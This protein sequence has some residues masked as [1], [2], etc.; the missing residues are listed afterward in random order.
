MFGDKITVGCIQN[1][2]GM[3]Y[4]VILLSCDQIAMMCCCY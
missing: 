4:I 2:T 1:W 3:H